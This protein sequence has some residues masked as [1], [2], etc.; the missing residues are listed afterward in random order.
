MIANSETGIKTVSRV[1]SRPETVK[2][3]PTLDTHR[4]NERV[5]GIIYKKWVGK[6]GENIGEPTRRSEVL[7]PNNAFLIEKIIDHFHALTH[8]S[9][10]L[11][12]HG[13]DRTNELPGFHIFQRGNPV[14]AP[15]I[16]ILSEAGQ[17]KPPDKFL[18][19]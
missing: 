4:C 8:L 13:K 17:W 11:I 12:R 9:L 3:T 7:H 14:T 18:S 5:N 19:A 1:R 10:S 2:H 6:G 16:A 15:R